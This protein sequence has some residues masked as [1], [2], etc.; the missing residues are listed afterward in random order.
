VSASSS[1]SSTVRRDGSGLTCATRSRLD[2]GRIAVLHRLEDRPRPVP[3]EAGVTCVDLGPRFGVGPVTGAPS[4]VA[5]DVVPSATSDAQNSASAV[6]RFCAAEHQ[7]PAIQSSPDRVYWFQYR[8]VE[9]GLLLLS[10]HVVDY[11]PLPQPRAQEQPLPPRGRS[12][13][14]RAGP[15]RT[16]VSCPLP[17]VLRCPRGR[18][19]APGCASLPRRTVH[20]SCVLRQTYPKV[21]SAPL[22]RWPGETSL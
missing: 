21:N 14:R 9:V 18:K 7:R 1:S 20:P 10:W 17:R 11:W 15:R 6:V 16:P 22:T 19:Y 5:E 13:H 3:P 2:W 4:G 12:A 8:D